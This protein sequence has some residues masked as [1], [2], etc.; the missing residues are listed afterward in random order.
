M[1]ILMFIYNFFHLNTHV[2]SFI[3]F[4]IPLLF[5][6]TPSHPHPPFAA[7]KR[8]SCANVEKIL[9]AWC[10]SLQRFLVLHFSMHNKINWA[11]AEAEPCNFFC[12]CLCEVMW[13]CECLSEI[14][15]AQVRYN[16]CEAWELWGL[17]DDIWYFILRGLNIRVGIW[18]EFL[19]CE[20]VCC[21]F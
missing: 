13:E 3:L 4:P 12:K 1:I 14:M 7:V 9:M 19:S 5:A 18:V 21:T 2:F 20:W 15:S 8:W 6:L 16:S 11:E 10:A 17:R